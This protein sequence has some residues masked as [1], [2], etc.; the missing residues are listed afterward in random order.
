V[1][2][3]RCAHNTQPTKHTCVLAVDCHHHHPTIQCSAHAPA[4][5]PVERACTGAHAGSVCAASESGSAMRGTDSEATHAQQT[6]RGR[7]HV[8]ARPSSVLLGQV[9]L[10]AARCTATRRTRSGQTSSQGRLGAAGAHTQSQVHTMIPVHTQLAV[11]RPHPT[12]SHAGITAPYQKRLRCFGKQH[13]DKHMHTRDDTP[14]ACNSTPVAAALLPQPCIKA[15]AANKH[16]KKGAPATP[17]HTAP[18]LQ[19]CSASHAPQAC[20]PH[21][22]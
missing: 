15:C 1:G 12:M 2:V 19:H 20:Q 22:G 10:G 13:P 14:G 5:T 8:H 7:A 17:Q 18:T 21:W 3:K 6:S 11:L 4:D 16:N 9:H